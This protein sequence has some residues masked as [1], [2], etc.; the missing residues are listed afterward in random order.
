MV[1]YA[2]GNTKVIEIILS[3]DTDKSEAFK[4]ESH[5]T[6]IGYP[7]PWSWISFSLTG[8]K[9]LK[10]QP[11]VYDVVGLIEDDKA[12]LREGRYYQI[13]EKLFFEPL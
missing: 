2:H 9:Q 8:L 10:P 11:W 4:F 3:K 7:T 5:I 12:V 13:E 1:V 6:H